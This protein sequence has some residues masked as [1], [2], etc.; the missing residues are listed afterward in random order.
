MPGGDEDN[1]I[2]A[3]VQAATTVSAVL[4]ALSF[5]YSWGEYDSTGVEIL[6]RLAELGRGDPEAIAALK[7]GAQGNIAKTRHAARRALSD[8]AEQGD[9]LAIEVLNEFEAQRLAREATQLGISV[10]ELQQRRQAQ[11]A[12]AAARQQADREELT[13]EAARL[14]ITEAEVQEGRHRAALAQQAER[15]AQVSQQRYGDS[16]FHPGQRVVCRISGWQYS[17]QVGVVERAVNRKFVVVQFE[18]GYRTI[19]SDDQFEA[20]HPQ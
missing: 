10:E 2:L 18:D 13:A 4:E 20:I 16:Q 11:K 17:D 14:G 3:R 12:A 8:L 6:T 15:S 9:E 1:S 5:W 19:Q 7:R